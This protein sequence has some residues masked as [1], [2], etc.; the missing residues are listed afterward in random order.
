MKTECFYWKRLQNDGA[1]NFVQ[2]F[3]GPLC[4][5]PVHTAQRRTEYYYYSQRAW[6]LR[7]DDDDDGG[8]SAG[9]GACLSL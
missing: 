8:G 9:A 2:F 6:R 4:I 3:S 7:D 1:L 5:W